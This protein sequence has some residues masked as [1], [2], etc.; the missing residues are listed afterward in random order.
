MLQGLRQPEVEHLHD[1]VRPE[2]D[3]GWLE[4]PMDNPSLVGSLQRLGD[5]LCDRQCVIDRNRPLRNAVGERRSFH[6][7]Q[8]QRT[9]AAALL[10][11]V[12][13]R[14]VRMIQ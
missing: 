3:V 1:A 6:E 11:A 10:K 5:L 2:L 12:N 13:R 14:D 4:I 8:D 9:D 7:F